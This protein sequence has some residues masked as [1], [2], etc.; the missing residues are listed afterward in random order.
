MRLS[1]AQRVSSER[2]DSCSLRST[3]DTWVSTV[4]TE[5]NSSL[6]TSG[7]LAETLL[8]WNG[9]SLRQYSSS[10]AGTS[11]EAAAVQVATRFTVARECGLPEDV[12]QEYF[13]ASEDQIEVN[14]ISPTGYPMRMLKHS[15]AIGA[16]IRPN[17][18]EI[19]RAH[20]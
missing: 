13:K 9:S 1:A 19:G 10:R 5:M 4:L 17:C 2:F 11:L 14:Q 15:P 16:G 18:E 12:Q 8:S 20:V 6:A 3:E 7:C